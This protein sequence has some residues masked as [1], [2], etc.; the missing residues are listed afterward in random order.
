M[1]IEALLP[2][3]YVLAMCDPGP[4]LELLTPQAT[5]P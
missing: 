2:N 1:T 4:P 5:L 3:Y